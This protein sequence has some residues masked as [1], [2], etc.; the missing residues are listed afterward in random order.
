M[1]RKKKLPPHTVQS[2]KAMPLAARYDAIRECVEDEKRLDEDV[3]LRY[4]LA[5]LFIRRT[6]GKPKEGETKDARE[7]ISYGRADRWNFKQPPY[8]NIRDMHLPPSLK[9]SSP[10]ALYRLMH[11]IRPKKLV[12][13]MDYYKGGIFRFFSPDRRYL[14]WVGFHKCEVELSFYCP[15]KDLFI[16]EDPPWPEALRLEPKTQEEANNWYNP[17]GAWETFIKQPENHKLFMAHR[18]AQDAYQDQGIV[19]PWSSGKMRC[20]NEQGQAWMRLIVTLANTRHDIYP[21]NSFSV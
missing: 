8:D 13:P 14:C 2:L 20:K 19:V 3:S 10:E 12:S 18:E 16:P 6:A 4:D 1:P 7:R 11:F 15:R 9:A 5:P 17:G 21:G